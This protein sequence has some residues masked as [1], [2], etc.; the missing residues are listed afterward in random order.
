M[1]I[2]E[3]TIQEFHHFLGPRIR[4]AINNF[5]RSYRNQ[6]NGICEGNCGKE[7]KE[8]HSAHVQ[9]QGR[10]SIIEK[11]LSSSAI[12]GK[13]RCDIREIE[14]KIME[15]H[16]PIKNNF[17]FLCHKCHVEYDSNSIKASRKSSKQ[18]EVSSEEFRKIN[19]I[20][21]WAKRAHQVNHKI[22]KEYLQ[23][24]ERGSV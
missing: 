17:K 21:L 18:L 5:T 3:G 22:I 23:L 15:A 20:E 24:E 9:G 2:F 8:L 1:A 19:R 6:R 7:K 12:N 4:N 11:V 14:K 13:I 16:L 10:R